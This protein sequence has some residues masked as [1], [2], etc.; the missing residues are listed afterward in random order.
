MI[1]F[2][3]SRWK[4]SESTYHS[5]TRPAWVETSIEEKYVEE[6]KSQEEE[7]MENNEAKRN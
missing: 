7:A 3:F 2:F 5:K 1:F 4:E 6:G